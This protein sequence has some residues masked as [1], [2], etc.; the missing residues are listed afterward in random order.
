MKIR[1]VILFSILTLNCFAGQPRE[2]SELKK[3]FDK[4]KVDGSILIYNQ[5]ENTYIGYDL[6]RCN[7]ENE[8]RKREI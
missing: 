4:Y 1:L 5:N 8:K 2:I 7:L 6:E 3:I